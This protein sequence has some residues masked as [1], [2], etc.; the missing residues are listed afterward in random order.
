MAAVVL[1]P[2][3]L[4]AS[5]QVS[6][7]DMRK[8]LVK[9]V[10]QQKDA[11]KKGESGLKASGKFKGGKLDVDFKDDTERWLWF[12]LASLAI[13]VLLSILFWGGIFFLP[14]L[15]WTVGIICLVIWLV[16]KFL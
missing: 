2:A 12:G 13:A 1:A 7:K 10:S 11:L 8:E 14:G 4:R 3:A 15:F 6:A 9:K 16:K 5:Q